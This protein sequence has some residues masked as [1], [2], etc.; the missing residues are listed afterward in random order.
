[1]SG[2]ICHT[3]TLLERSAGLQQTPL[4]GVPALQDSW[5][6]IEDHRLHIPR[7]H[8]GV[9]ECCTLMAVPIA[10]PA[11]DATGPE[12][13]LLAADRSQMPHRRSQAAGNQVA[14]RRRPRPAAT[15]PT[16]CHTI[17]GHESADSSDP[18]FG[19]SQ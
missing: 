3:S 14:P 2:L 6:R 10:V 4:I 8:V 19:L 16:T 5:I 11:T 9:R 7:V 18:R 13:I 15:S 1:M 12:T 17:R